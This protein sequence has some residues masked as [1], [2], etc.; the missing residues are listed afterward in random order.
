MELLTYRFSLDT[1]KNGVQRTLQGFNTGD[2]ISRRLIISLV[3]NEESYALPLDNIVAAM[4]VKRPSQT[5]PSINECTIDGNQIIYDVPA[6]DLT[7]EGEVN[8][9]LKVIYGTIENPLNVLI[10]PRFS[11]D[12]H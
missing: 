3:E 7:E 5:D 8:Y 1:H 2:N 11:V 6:S 4:Y 12:F 10:S 9:Q